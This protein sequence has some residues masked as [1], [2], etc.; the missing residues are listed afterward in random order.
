VRIVV[1][2][3]N[4]VSAGT[5]STGKQF[6]SALSN[7]DHKNRYLVVVSSGY[8]YE[9][10]MGNENF[11]FK[12]YRRIKWLYKFWRIYQD[13]VGFRRLV[14][15]FKADA[16]IVL[17][18]FSPV[19]LGVPTVV[20]LRN[21]YYVDLSNF[22]QFGKK[23]KI[24]KKLE[25]FFFYLT[26]K[27]ANIFT[28]QSE[29]MKERLS[30]KWNVPDN[31]IRVIPNAISTA[32]VNM[33]KNVSGGKAKIMQAND[34]KFKILYVSRYYAHKNHKFIL[35][36][37]KQFQASHINDLVFIVTLDEHLD[38]VKAILR[39]IYDSNL[40]DFIYNIGEVSQ[41]ELVNW[42]QS[43]DI[44]FFPSYLETFG[45]AFL[46]AMNFGLPICAVDLPYARSVCDDAA[47]Y[48]Q[49]D[50]VED[51]AEEI[52]RLK[53]DIHLR[54]IMSSKSKERYCEFPSWEEVAGSYL[55]ILETLVISQLH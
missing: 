39:E 32:I 8:G 51:A 47:L 43:S 24:L 17:G 29:H 19:R 49:K 3:I 7:I 27:Q 48:Y 21:S 53:N 42:Y 11:Q 4:L 36:L 25:M 54:R 1:N 9:E 12:F 52:L 37:A 34:E 28:V 45:N 33:K 41:E 31:K 38:G 40:D 14:D 18:N 55:G 13:F 16:V 50:S 30:D 20:L 22:E 2:A 6:L 15:R 35:R 23:E 44:L 46:E 5:L 10:I 26:T